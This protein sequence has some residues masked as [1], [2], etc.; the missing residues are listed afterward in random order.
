[1]AHFDLNNIAAYTAWKEQK[2]T[3]YPQDLAQLMVKINNPAQLSSAEKTNL[4]QILT[5]TNLV[6]YEL[7]PESTVTQA[8]LL[9]LGEQMGLKNI[10]LTLTAEEDG[11]TPLQVS[12]SGPRQEYIPYTDQ[13]INWHTDGY[14]NPIDKPVCGML[15]H[16]SRPAWQGGV[17]QIVD[18][19]IVY[20]YLRDLNPDYIAALMQTDAMTIPANIVQ[21]KVLRPAATGPVISIIN[22]KL[23]IRYTARK[24]NIIWQADTT[25]SAAIAALTAFLSS[26]AKYIYTHGL[27]ANQGIICN[28]VLHNRSAFKNGSEIAQQRLFYRIRYYDYVQ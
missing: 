17:N 15:L 28:N 3:S 9:A 1:M 21:D 20:I 19:E 18:N 7:D 6:F 4:W 23:H 2:L 5:K 24:R 10:D 14:Y 13:A 25:L 16:C 12:S 11:V 27:Q 8:S 22:G 26:D